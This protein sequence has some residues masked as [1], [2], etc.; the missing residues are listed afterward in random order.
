[1]EQFEDGHHVRLRSR[2]RGTYLHADD[3]GLGV[4]LSRRRASMNA[5]WAVHIYQGDGGAQYLL[6][7]SAAY[8]RYLGA[9]DAPALRGH[10]ESRVEQ[11]DYG[12]WEEEAIRWQAAGIGSGDNILLRHVGGRRLRANGRYLSVDD[13]DSAGTMMHWVVERIPSREDTPRL[14]APTGLRLPRS[15]SFMLPW[16]VIQVEQAG[17]DESNASFPW[18][19]LVFRGRSAYHLRKKLASRLG[20][21]M[22]VSNLVMCVR[23]GMHGRPT[24]LVIDLPR[25]RQTLDI[26]VFMAGTPA[27]ADL[28]YPNVNAE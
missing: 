15:L 21:A 23:A 22:D 2:E 25:S 28:R 7:H 13:S 9:T 3:D 18:A 11:C 17:A 27:H 26:I 12:P 4:S 19:S 16:R 10:I 6:L 8:G 5:A 1:M 20:V 24:P 14:A